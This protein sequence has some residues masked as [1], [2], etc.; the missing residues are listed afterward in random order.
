LPAKENLKSEFCRKNQKVI[1][2]ISGAKI[3]FFLK[4][5]D[6]IGYGAKIHVIYF[7]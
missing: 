5:R 4:I 3:N 7:W 6:T 1:L 2:A